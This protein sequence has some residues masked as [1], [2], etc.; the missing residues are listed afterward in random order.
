MYLK[1][2]TLFLRWFTFKYAILGLLKVFLFKLMKSFISITSFLFVVELLV[3]ATLTHSLHGFPSLVSHPWGLDSFGWLVLWM[4]HLHLSLSIA[5]SFFSLRER[6]S[7]LINLAIVSLG[8]LLG[9]CQ[10]Q[11]ENTS[12][13]CRGDIALLVRRGRSSL[14]LFHADL[15]LAVTAS[16]QPPVFPITSPR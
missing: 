3:L 9:L 13:Q 4:R 11:Q 16:I 5:S 12:P 2:T 1:S 6:R 10:V 15:I 14:K 8:V 7:A